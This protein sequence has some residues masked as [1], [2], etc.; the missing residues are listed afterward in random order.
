MSQHPRMEV[1]FTYSDIVRLIDY[2]LLS[3]CHETT[4]A[5]DSD[6]TNDALGALLV[7]EE[8]LRST[9]EMI[10]ALKRIARLEGR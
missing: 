1:R 9:L 4:M 10:A 3:A 2:E 8:K 5:R 6:T 7:A